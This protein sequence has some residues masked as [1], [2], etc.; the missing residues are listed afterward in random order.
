MLAHE[1]V[2]QL[3]LERVILVPTGEA[4]HKVIDP[5]PGAEVRLEMT[6]VAAGDDDV[7]EASD[8]EVRRDGPSYSFRTLEELRDEAPSDELTLLMGSDVAASLESWKEPRR[9]VELASIGV[10]TRPGTIIDEAEAVLERLGC[11][12][13]AE[14]I[15]MPGLDISS[16]RVRRRVA[17]GRPIRYLVPD[18]VERFISERGLYS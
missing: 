5:E 7:I 3:G 12:G 17:A 16:T 10:A 15:R 6:R 14:T 8:V 4:P 9:V 1:A 2:S 18:E 13:R 11:E